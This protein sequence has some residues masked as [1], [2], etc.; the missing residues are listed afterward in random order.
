MEPI[1]RRNTPILSGRLGDERSV[2]Q[3]EYQPFHR[4]V[5]AAPNAHL[6]LE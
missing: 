3:Q 2:D 1:D 5:L 4:G 6:L